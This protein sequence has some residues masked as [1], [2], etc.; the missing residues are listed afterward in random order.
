[1]EGVFVRGTASTLVSPAHAEDNH[2]PCAV[3]E[4]GM[5]LAEVSIT[6]VQNGNLKS[7]RVL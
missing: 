7:L 2:T 1:M 6:D 4:S 5:C 3:L